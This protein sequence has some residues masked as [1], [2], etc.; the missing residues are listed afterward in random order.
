[1]NQALLLFISWMD[2][3]S[4]IFKY[5][6]AT[7][8][9]LLVWGTYILLKVYA[10]YRFYHCL[11]VLVTNPILKWVDRLYK[12]EQ[13]KWST[14]LVILLW[15]IVPYSNYLF[16]VFTYIGIPLTYLIYL[17]YKKLNKPVY[18]NPFTGK[19]KDIKSN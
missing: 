4:F 14:V 17:L 10:E 7:G 8:L 6:L 5:L 16:V 12:D 13:I 19:L 9:N 1:M 18:P 15:S 2:S 3:T 11:Q